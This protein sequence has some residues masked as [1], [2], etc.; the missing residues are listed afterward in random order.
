MP[1]RIVCMNRYRNRVAAIVVSIAISALVYADETPQYLSKTGERVTT[2]EHTALNYRLDLSSEAYT[3]V[4]FSERVPDAS[5]AAIRFKPNAFAIVIVENLPL[6]TTAEEYAELVRLAMAAD[7]EARDDTVVTGHS[8]LGVVTAKG[9]RVSQLVLRAEVKEKPISYVLSAMVD[10]SRAFQLLTMSLAGDETA[11]RREADRFLDSFSII[12]PALNAEAI[13]GLRSVKNY[14]SAGFGYGVSARGDGWQAWPNLENEIDGSDFGA[15]SNKGYGALVSPVC[16]DGPAPRR[17]TIYSVMLQEFGADYPSDFIQREED[18]EIENATGKFFAGVDTSEGDEYLYHHWVV[19]NDRCAYTLSVWGLVDAENLEED[20]DRVGSTFEVYDRATVHEDATEQELRVNAHLL[21]KLGIQYYEARSYRDAFRY[22]DSAN[23]ANPN[24]QSYVTNGLRALAD[25]DAE[26]EAR[27]WLQPRLGPFDDNEVVQSWVAW[28]AYKTRD[29]ETAI[30]VYRK[31]F[32]EGYREDDEFTAYLTMLADGGHWEEVDRIYATY[33]SGGIN[34]KTRLLKVQ[35]LSRRGKRDEALALLDD[36]TRGKPLDADLV[37]ERI[38]ILEDMERPEEIVTLAQ[39]LID[40]GFASLESYYYKGRAEYQ[41]RTYDA[42]RESFEAAQKFA[43]ANSTVRDYLEAIDIA[44][45]KGDVSSIVSEIKAV[46]LPDDLAQLFAVDDLEGSDAGYGS[47]FLADIVGYGFSGGEKLFRT[48]YQKIRILDDNGISDFST[49]EFDFDPS[50]EQLFVNKLVVRD[51][52]GVE[53]ANG[54]SDA[55]YITSDEDGYEASTERT[56]HLPV[57]SLAPGTVIEVV[58]TKQTSVERGSFPLETV[59]LSGSRPIAYSALFVS[60]KTGSIKYELNDVPR[61]RKSGKALVWELT[62]PVAL[63]WEPLQPYVDQL[64]PWVQLGTVGDEWRSVGNEYLGKIDDKLDTS[65]VAERATRLIE[66]IQDE[67]RQ[68][69]IL[70]AYVQNEIH[71]EAIEFGRRAFIPKT[72]RETLRDRYGD[73]KDHAVLLRSMLASVGIDASL[74]LVNLRQQI[75]PKLPNTDQFDHMIVAVDTAAGRRFIDATDKNMRLG[76]LA[77]RAMAGNHALLLSEM[78]ELVK[79]P[80]YPADL[81]GVVIERVVTPALNGT[82]TVAEN[83]RL[84]GYQAADL[85]GQLR[86][87]E[88]SEL[89]RSLQN[90]V[91]NRYTDAELTDYFVDNVFDAEYDLL[92]EL[93]YT[94]PVESGGMFEAPGFL[95]AFYLEYGRVADRR[96]PFEFEFPLHLTASTSVKVPEGQSVQLGAK[97]PSSGESKFGVWRRDVTQSDNAVHIQFDYQASER[98]FDAD[99]YREFSDFQR[100]AVDAVEQPLILE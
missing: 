88:K 82:V 20:L 59:Y 27:D 31:L 25:L 70:S 92:L 44:V 4:D 50:Y 60:G 85:R 39:Q 53:L 26:Q 22:F 62:S 33:T 86:D 19:M 5:F 18:I 9:L 41:M 80:D 54:D 23:A 52:N 12:D 58:V 97:R 32:A 99:D 78:P 43:P 11:A 17:N 67:A 36:M 74:A 91:A 28:L 77:P 100:K 98:R 3:Y 56:V 63:R 89:Q 55:Y 2:F 34:D 16:W 10:G 81:T 21:N 45:G 30:D 8:N 69:E 14:T 38:D 57:P 87:I 79:I 76:E 72:A 64:V 75:V 73:C 1:G 13:P 40:N 46:A 29:F 35:L 49:L 37:Y 90:W 6:D 42:A 93:E 51:A 7:L 84:T 71:Y 65:K 95:E 83:A 15:L 68:I 66:G 24:V 96:F 47:E 48:V 61:S 94:L